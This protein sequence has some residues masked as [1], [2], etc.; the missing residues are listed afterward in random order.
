MDKT[1]SPKQETMAVCI[2]HEPDIAL[3]ELCKNVSQ[4]VL[5]KLLMLLRIWRRE[6][7]SKIRWKDNPNVLFILENQLPNYFF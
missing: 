4:R 6:S 3:T 5:Q 1:T 7:G 2:E